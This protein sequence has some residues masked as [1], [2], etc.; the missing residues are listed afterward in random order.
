MQTHN[1]KY[2]YEVHIASY[3]AADWSTLPKPFF[4]N[5]VSPPNQISTIATAEVRTLSKALLLFD[6]IREW[7]DSQKIFNT[8][9]CR[10]TLEEMV[11]MSDFDAEMDRDSGIDRQH[12]ET[13][14]N[15]FIAFSDIHADGVWKPS[16]YRSLVQER[17]YLPM[18]Y[19][20][21]RGEDL[22]VLT[23]HFLYPDLAMKEFTYLTTIL[24]R[25]GFRGTVSVENTL[26]VAVIG[27]PFTRPVVV[28][29]SS[30]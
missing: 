29:K 1:P 18:D 21:R 7:C 24:G 25:G 20:T 16:L 17:A 23:L 11:V 30:R 2:N 28:H 4:L 19:T 15:A 22:S 8:Q 27:P 9:G 13:R 10:I 5:N 12:W 26:A 3:G 6:K 14:H